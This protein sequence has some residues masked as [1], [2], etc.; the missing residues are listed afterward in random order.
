M[1]NP[2]QSKLSTAKMDKHSPRPIAGSGVMGTLVTSPKQSAGLGSAAGVSPAQ[3]TSSGIRRRPRTAAAYA[4][5]RVREPRAGAAATNP[6]PSG[7]PRT[8][9]RASDSLWRTRRPRRDDRTS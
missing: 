1:D 4:A 7:L 3:A 8:P 2:L 5:D 6:T 9:A